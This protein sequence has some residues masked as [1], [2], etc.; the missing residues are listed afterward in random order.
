MKRGSSTLIKEQV[1]TMNLKN[2]EEMKFG[3]FTLSTKKIPGAIPT[4]E[5]TSSGKEIYIHP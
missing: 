4:G 5:K 2:V 1:K 3:K